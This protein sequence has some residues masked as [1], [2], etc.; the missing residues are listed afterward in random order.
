MAILYGADAVYLG[1]KKFGLRA[2]GGNFSREEMIE[3][4]KFAHERGRKVYV[5]VNIFPHNSDI[6][7]VLPYLKELQEINIDAVLVS[8]IGLFTL[9]KMK[10]RVWKCILARRRTIRTG[11]R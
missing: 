3:G 10:C 6:N 1:G 7:S 9:I 8:D 11:W 4:V 2:Y 5:T